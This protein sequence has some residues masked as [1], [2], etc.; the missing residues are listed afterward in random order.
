[1]HLEICLQQ[2][3]MKVCH[4]TK[5]NIWVCLYTQL[6]KYIRQSKWGTKTCSQR[7]S[8]SCTKTAE[9]GLNINLQVGPIHHTSV[10]DHN[11]HFACLKEG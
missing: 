5:R 9:V 7:T 8:T 4:E 6:K 10:K 1:M 3:N 2:C 11:H